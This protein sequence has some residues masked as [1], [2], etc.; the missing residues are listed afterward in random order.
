MRKV[1]AQAEHPVFVWP[2]LIETQSIDL[3]F[4]IEEIIQMNLE[5]A[6]I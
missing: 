4:F 1:P 3:L 5:V 6:I 2:L